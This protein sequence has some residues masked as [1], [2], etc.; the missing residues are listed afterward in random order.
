MLLV[1]LGVLNG[2]LLLPVLLSFF[3]PRSEVNIS[4]GIAFLDILS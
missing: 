4:F 1:A 3:G 2:L